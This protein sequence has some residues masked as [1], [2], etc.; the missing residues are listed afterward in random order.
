MGRIVPREIVGRDLGSGS[1]LISDVDFNIERCGT[2]LL[3]QLAVV[4]GPVV[5]SVISS[6]IVADCAC[7]VVFEAMLGVGLRLVC[8]VDHGCSLRK[9]VMDQDRDNEKTSD[10]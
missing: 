3:D 9:S 5:G 4:A 8:H 10:E 7:A 2:P 6:L 1:G